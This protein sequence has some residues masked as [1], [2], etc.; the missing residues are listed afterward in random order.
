MMVYAWG[1]DAVIVDCGMTMP[2]AGHH[3]VDYVIPDIRAL[4]DLDLKL[5]AILL[6]HAHEDH[7]GALPYL[8]P[9][10]KLPIWGLPATL[11]LV[12]VKLEEFGLRPPM[13]RYPALGRRVQ[14]GPFRVEALPVT[15]SIMDAACLALQTPL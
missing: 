5:H 8:W 12:E 3:G 14:I 1:R 10:L 13:K 2:E 4:K 11:K 6:T 7:I 15:H 9:Q